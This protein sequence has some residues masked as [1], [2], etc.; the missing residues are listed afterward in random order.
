[1]KLRVVFG[2]LITFLVMRWVGCE[3]TDTGPVKHLTNRVWVNKA[4]SG[5]RDPVFSFMLL[6]R[7]KRKLGVMMNASSYRFAGD[8]IMYKIEGNHLTIVVPQDDVKARFK[9]RTWACKDAP[10][11]F[12]LCLELKRNGRSVVLYSERKR[13]LTEQA[14]LPMGLDANALD[15]FEADSVA[16]DAAPWFDELTFGSA[17]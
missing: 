12:D 10:K 4:A 13:G 2:L 6:S 17:D 16:A 15:A 5:P 14:M 1:M 7:M 9:V 8:L 11:P 3:P